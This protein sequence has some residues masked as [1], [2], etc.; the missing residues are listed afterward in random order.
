M[1]ACDPQGLSLVP[2]PSQ[3]TPAQACVEPSKGNFQ[4]QDAKRK[5]ERRDQLGC[6]EH[7][8]LLVLSSI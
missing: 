1:E 7:I 2:S 6:K 8:P 4:R 5:R 3:K